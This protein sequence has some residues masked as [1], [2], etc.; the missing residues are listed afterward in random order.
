MGHEWWS[1][2]CFQHPT[3]EVG[4]AT[5]REGGSIPVVAS[6]EEIFG[7][8]TLLLGWGLN[9]DNLYSPNEH[10]HLSNFHRGT[11]ASAKLWEELGR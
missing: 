8:E 6:F 4:R 5:L 2:L 7:V 11:L 9:S 10:F 1:I 3:D